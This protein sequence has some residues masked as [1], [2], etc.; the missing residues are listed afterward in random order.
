[1]TNNKTDLIQT[2]KATLLTILVR[3]IVKPDSYI[4][5]LYVVL[6]IIGKALHYYN[7]K[8]ITVS[9]STNSQVIQFTYQL[10]MGQL[11]YSKHNLKKV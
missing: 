6:L 11:W 3:V 2:G 1:M 4:F 5:T 9:R 10:R 8:R 7:G